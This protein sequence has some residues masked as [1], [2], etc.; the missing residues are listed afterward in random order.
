MRAGWHEEGCG[1]RRER[2]GDPSWEVLCT[3]ALYTIVSMYLHQREAFVYPPY[4]P[5]IGAPASHVLRHLSSV[6]NVGYLFSISVCA[7]FLPSWPPAKLPAA[8]TPLPAALAT[9]L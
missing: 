3:L 1:E 5:T 6:Q 4:I 9:Y 8:C 7:Q 2:E